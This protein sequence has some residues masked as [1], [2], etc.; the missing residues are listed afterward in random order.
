MKLLVSILLFSL[1]FCSF[2][3]LEEEEGKP[4]IFSNIL[5]K[6]YFGPKAGVHA[7]KS[8]FRDDNPLLLDTALNLK[9]SYKFGYSTGLVLTYHV[10][11]R[12]SVHS[13]LY[14][15]RE[16]KKFSGGFEGKFSNNAIY[17]NI[18]F[19]I[20]FRISFER[21]VYD[22]FLSVGPNFSYWLGGNGIIKSDELS[23]F[24]IDQSEYKI[25]FRNPGKE[26]VDGKLAVN[27]EEPNRIQVGLTFGVGAF[28]HTLPG[29]HIM[30][31]LRYEI[32]HSF[33]G[34]DENVDVGIAEYFENF[35][36]ATRLMSVNFGYV[37]E[38]NMGA[39]QQG[40]TSF[41]TI[42]S[43]SQKKGKTQGKSTIFNKKGNTTLGKKKGNQGKSISNKGNSTLRKKS[44]NQGKSI[45]NKKKPTKKSITNRRRRRKN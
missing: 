37:F 2:A 41:G 25:L 13:E 21:K 23:E 36:S 14:Y 8:I 28:F 19:P 34:K 12:F 10:S 42:N 43:K 44:G 15:S 3:Q 16:G 39:G 35:K 33:L 26:E 30:V 22:W 31:D 5:G 20:L 1:S 29:Q 17:H 4:G 40:Q 27:L 7:Y 24:F 6:L 38:I 9:S 11:D 45:S 18:D 32:G